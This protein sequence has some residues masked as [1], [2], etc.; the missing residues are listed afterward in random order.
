MKKIIRH[1]LYKAQ[2]QFCGTEFAFEKSDVQWHP[3]SDNKKI[4]PFTSCPCCGQETPA[5]TDETTKIKLFPEP[6]YEEIQAD[7]LQEKIDEYERAF[8]AF[9]IIKDKNA[10]VH[11]AKMQQQIDTF[12]AALLHI[13]ERIDNGNKCNLV[14]TEPLDDNDKHFINKIIRFIDEHIKTTENTPYEKSD[15]SVRR[16]SKRG[17]QPAL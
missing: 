4:M 14:Y 8:Q 13:N 11:I 9:N 12:K 7:Q 15:R 16:L 2:C 1:V 10:V 3:A 5:K 6:D 17:C